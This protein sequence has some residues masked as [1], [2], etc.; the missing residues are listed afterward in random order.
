MYFEAPFFLPGQA[1]VYGMLGKTQ[2]GLDVAGEALDIVQ[3]TEECWSEAE[4]R[5]IKGELL[6]SSGRV[7]EAEVCFRQ[8]IEV[9]RRQEAKSWELR[10]TLSLSRLLQKQRKSEEA[11]ELLSEIYAWFTE[12]FDTPDLQEARALLD[13]L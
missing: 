11:R 6:Q 9:A 3:K 12:G 2:E 10:A 13:L 4:A 7:S 5:R 1:E 8:A